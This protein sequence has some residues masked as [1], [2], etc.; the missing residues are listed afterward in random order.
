MSTISGL[1]SGGTWQGWSVSSAS[2]VLGYQS[3]ESDLLGADFLASS[4]TDIVTLSEEA[5]AVLDSQ[6]SD[7]DSG[8]L[9]SI[10]EDMSASQVASLLLT[11]AS[12]EVLTAM[13]GDLDSLD[14]LSGLT[15]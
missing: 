2:S 11:V 9:S 7:S 5:Q 15:A 3:E 4:Y 14:L 8:D 6:V 10:M 1:F 13:L 12:G